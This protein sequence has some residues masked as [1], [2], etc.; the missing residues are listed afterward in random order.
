MASNFDMADYQNL[1]HL[2]VYRGLYEE[3]QHHK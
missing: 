2:V 1:Y 3:L